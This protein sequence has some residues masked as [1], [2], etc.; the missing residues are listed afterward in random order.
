[1]EPRK[2][3]P[4]HHSECVDEAWSASENL[5]RI[6]DDAGAKV[7]KQMFAWMDP[8]GDPDSKGSF[9]MPH[10][11]V[12]EEGNVGAANMKAC[13]S[14]IGALNGA[15]GGADIPE[16]DRPA[17]HKHL[18]THMMDGEM[19]PPELKSHIAGDLEHR[20]FSLVEVRIDEGGDM[21]AK[22]RGHAAVFDSLS[23]PLWGFR[24]KIAPGAFTKTL[25][26]ADIRALWNHNPD[27]VLG[28]N[29]AKTLTLAEDEKGLAI[30]ITP[31]DTQW[32]RDLMVTMKRGDVD[33]MS[34]AFRVVKEQWEGTLDNPIR[35]LLEV[36]MDG[37][38]VSPVT[39]PAYPA[40]DVG[41]RSI[42]AGAGIDQD[43]LTSMLFRAQRGLPMQPADRDLINASI[44]ALKSYLPEVRQEPSPEN[45]KTQARLAMLRR[46]L[47][48]ADRAV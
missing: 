36:D 2:A 18:A 25:K 32:A 16:A 1:M 30:E 3:M 7:L 40:T 10:H 15:R 26:K 24:E 20:S 33:Q 43:A 47:E 35:T 46:R 14:G 42:L 29:K 37:G 8:E 28:R 19:E 9:K 11:M 44:Q 12:D 17:V 22:M 45:A 13:M 23:V 41:I 6:P 5:K 4:V 39:Y 34:F 31:P 27:Y 48:I 38:D 21:P